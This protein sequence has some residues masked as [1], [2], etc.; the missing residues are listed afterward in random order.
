MD[1]G[2]VGGDTAGKRYQVIVADYGG[3]DAVDDRDV[4]V[5]RAEGVGNIEPQCAPIG[6]IVN[7]YFYYSFTNS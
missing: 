5:M 6:G 4:P 3:I 2:A 1:D 7:F